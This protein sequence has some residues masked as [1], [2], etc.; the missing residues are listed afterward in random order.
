MLTIDIPE[1]AEIAA[2]RG[3]EVLDR[4]RPEWFNDIDIEKL[5]MASATKCI[6][7]QLWGHYDEH[8]DEVVVLIDPDHVT[9]YPDNSMELETTS[10]LM[11]AHGFFVVEPFFAEHQNFIVPSYSYNDLTAAWRREIDIR[12]RSA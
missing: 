2:M 4:I 9:T 3:A 7:G 1:T 12:R 11:L 8:K 5:Y 10:V 6:V